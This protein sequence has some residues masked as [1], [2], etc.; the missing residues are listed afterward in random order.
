MEQ[1]GLSPIWKAIQTQGLHS[2]DVTWPGWAVS[3]LVL[4]FALLWACFGKRIL[5]WLAL[6]QGALLGIAAGFWSGLALET[7]RAEGRL[8]LDIWLDVPGQ[9]RLSLY[10]VVGA[11]LGGL[12]LGLVGRALSRVFFFL[13]GGAAASLALVLALR[14]FRASVDQPLLLVI[15]FLILTGVVAI[16]LS[17]RHPAVF[18]GVWGGLWAAVALVWP[19]TRLFARVGGPLWL[20]Y[21]SA[22]GLGILVAIAGTALQLDKEAERQNMRSYQQEVGP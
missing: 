11:L 5:P 7:A 9:L 2:P 1:T 21:L 6:V 22:V 13:G 8:S 16:W 17:Y 15:L 19:M 12:L 4:L 10:G 20:P 18:T 3:G 14:L